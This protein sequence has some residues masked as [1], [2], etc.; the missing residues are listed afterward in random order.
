MVTPSRARFV[1]TAG[2]T[3]GI[4]CLIF[5]GI[6][7]RLTYSDEADMRREI[8][9]LA[10]AGQLNAAQM[11]YAGSSRPREALYDTVS[12]P[13]QVHNL[14]DDPAERPRLERMRQRLRDWI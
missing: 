7:P 8:T 12:D 5:R 3:Y 13:F 6:S 10:Q 2:S 1:T 14:A 11:T 4:I 9:E